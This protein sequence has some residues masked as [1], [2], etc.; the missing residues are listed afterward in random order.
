MGLWSGVV[1]TVFAISLGL[2]VL[3]REHLPQWLTRSV[4]AAWRPP[5]ALLETLHSGRVNDHITMVIVGT[6]LLCGVFFAAFR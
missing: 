2:A 3:Y 4:A 1:S 5:L 6:A